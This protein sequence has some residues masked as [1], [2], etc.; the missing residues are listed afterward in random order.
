MENVGCRKPT[1][2]AWTK[3]S[4]RELIKTR[5]WLVSLSRNP[6]FW[7]PNFD[8][9][10]CKCITGHFTYLDWRYLAYLAIRNV[11]LRCMLGEIPPKQDFIWYSTFNLGTWNDPWNWSKSQEPEHGAARIPLA[12]FRVSWWARGFVDT[13]FLHCVVGM[14]QVRGQRGSQTL[15]FFPRAHGKF[16]AVASQKKIYENTSDGYSPTTTISLISNKFQ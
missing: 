6:I 16:W 1:N 4:G 10:R 3:T 14:P 8:T 13:S 11:Y 12:D 15:P 5:L 7:A 9:Y 2:M